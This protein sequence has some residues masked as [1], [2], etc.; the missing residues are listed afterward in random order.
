MYRVI[1]VRIRRF[2]RG[3]NDRT[4]QTFRRKITAQVL[5]FLS[6]DKAIRVEL[7]L[8]IPVRQNFRRNPAYD[9]NQTLS[10]FTSRIQTMRYLTVAFF[11]DGSKWQFGRKTLQFFSETISNRLPSGYLIDQSIKF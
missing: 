3:V 4:Y 5:L 2:L 6:N 8:K 11:G 7:S 9:A 1:P 10:F